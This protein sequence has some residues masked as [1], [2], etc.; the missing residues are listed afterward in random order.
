MSCRNFEDQIVEYLDG[1]LRSESIA[2]LEGHLRDCAACAAEFAATK[3]ALAALDDSLAD[4]PGMDVEAGLAAVCKRLAEDEVE[5]PATSWYVTLRWWLGGGLA[6][7]A[8]AALVAVTYSGPDPSI[9]NSG[10]PPGSQQPETAATLP[11]RADAARMMEMLEEMPL[12]EN[13]DCFQEYDHLAA[14]LDEN[15]EK[16]EEIL[17][18]VQG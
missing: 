2:A 8:A 1:E 16:L 18:E 12:Y 7:A 4:P 15:P 13:L 14:M 3:E 17:I 6:A 11:P 10:A 9:I 5:T